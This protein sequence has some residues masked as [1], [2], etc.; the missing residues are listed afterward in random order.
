MGDVDWSVYEKTKLDPI[1]YHPSI[2]RHLFLLPAEVQEFLQA[3]P[4][5]T[6]LLCGAPELPPSSPPDVAHDVAVKYFG[7]RVQGCKPIMNSFFEHVSRFVAYPTFG[8]WTHG[9]DKASKERFG[10]ILSR[11][12]FISFQYELQSSKSR[13]TLVCRDELCDGLQSRLAN[14]TTEKLGC[15]PS[16]WTPVSSV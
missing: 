8:Q 13:I 1:Y 12:A 9:F 15:A 11:G 14:A 10:S 7:M 2:H 3:P 6:E 16:S 5:P 4:P